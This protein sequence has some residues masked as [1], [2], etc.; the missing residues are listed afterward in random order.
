MKTT[1]IGAL[2][3]LGAVLAL[4][5]RAQQGGLGGTYEIPSE[6]RATKT[7]AG[8]S[9]PFSGAFA[10]EAHIGPAAKSF[11]LVW[12]YREPGQGDV[13]LFQR[14]PLTFTPTEICAGATLGEL[15]VAGTTK[16]GITKIVRYVYA[17]P[18]LDQAGMPLEAEL[19]SS[20]IVFS[21]GATAPTRDVYH[22]IRNR[23]QPGRL[24]VEFFNSREIYDLDLATGNA[25]KVVA[26]TWQ[27]SPALFLTQ[28]HEP[29]DIV[30]SREHDGHYVYFFASTI[31]NELEFTPILLDLDKNGTLDDK[32][33]LDEQGW[34]VL[35]Y[36]DPSRYAD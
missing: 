16:H 26:S 14:E 35:G 24:F 7:N 22:M 11:D 5:S 33:F 3:I 29:H 4:A 9:F 18:Q 2:A 30:Y 27:P 31:P 21:A 36:G 10:L 17:T 20:N 19:L 8:C 32:L 23:A 1:I 13:P 15:L 28:L 34:Q 25:T 12:R 6:L